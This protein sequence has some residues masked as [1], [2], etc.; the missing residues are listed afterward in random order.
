MKDEAQRTV[1]PTILTMKK[2]GRVGAIE[3]PHLAQQFSV[4]GVPRSVIN[5]KDFIEGAVPEKVYVQKILD[6]VK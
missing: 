5:E 2:E 1:I 6:A 3:F 4:A